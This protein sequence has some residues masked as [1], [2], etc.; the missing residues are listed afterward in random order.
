MIVFSVII[1]TLTIMPEIGRM[2]CDEMGGSWSP[3][4]DVGCRMKPEECRAV[5]GVPEECKPSVGL[6]CADVCH[7]R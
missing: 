5:G 1:T 3:Y 7:F 6:S 2:Q 4:F